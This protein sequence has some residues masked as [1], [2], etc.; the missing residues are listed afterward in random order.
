MFRKLHIHMTL[1]SILITGAILTFM[2]GA[3]LLITESN[4]RQ[5]YYTIFTN[6]A[7]SCISYLESQGVISHRW[8]QQSKNNYG[9]DMQILDGDVPLYFER[10]RDSNDLTE[11]FSL[12][13]EESAANYGLDLDRPSAG[14]TLSQ[15]EIFKV[16]GYYACTAR[17]PKN[18]KILNAVFIHS[19][20][21]QSQQLFTLRLVF[22]LSVIAALLALAVFS[23]FFTQKMIRPLEKSRQQQTQFIASASH[24]LRSPLAVILSSIQAMKSASPEEAACFSANILSEGNRMSRLIDDMLALANADNQS[25]SI[26]PAPCELDTLLLQIYEKYEP[27]MREKKLALSVNLPEEPLPPCVCDA[28]RISQVLG[29]L[30]DNCLAYVPTGGNI[31]LSLSRTKNCFRLTVTDNGPGIP[32]HKKE[33]VFERFYRGDSARRDKQHFGLGLCIAREIIDLHHGSIKVTDAP[34]KGA[35]FMIT[36]PA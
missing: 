31:H 9:I 8:I 19:L 25:W 23:W 27:Q 1:F 10:L 18:D 12:V 4:I 32:D 21:A 13:K 35:E 5:N 22:L 36:L 26:H 7:Y 15:V 16:P 29:I 28:S 30:L 14:Q 33:A 2:A 20:S 24:E 34:G 6:N 11:I 3:C 17:I